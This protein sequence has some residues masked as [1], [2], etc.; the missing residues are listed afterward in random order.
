[1][2]RTHKFLFA[3]V[4]CLIVLG[5]A[6]N[7]EA[8][9]GPVPPPPE[10]QK[11]EFLLH[12]VFPGETMASIAKWYTGKEIDWKELAQYNPDLKPRNLKPGAMVKIPLLMATVHDS[13]SEH[14]T[15]PKKH[16][17]GTPKTPAAKDTAPPES[18]EFFGPK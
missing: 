4:A 12:H 14:S 6:S 15:A 16:R 17:K 5:C 1:M 18:E 7:K 9:T 10:V 8:I 3:L 11:P 2:R 13:Q